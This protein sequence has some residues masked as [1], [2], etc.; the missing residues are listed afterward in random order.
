METRLGFTDAQ[1]PDVLRK[2]LPKLNENDNT[3]SAAL[4]TVP[5]EKTSAGLG[6]LAGRSC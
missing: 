2:D 4:E 1:I 5:A 3:F 6:R